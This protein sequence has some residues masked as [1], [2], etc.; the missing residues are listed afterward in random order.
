MPLGAARGGH[1]W[2]HVD[3]GGP[4]HGC[5]SLPKSDMIMLLRTL[6]PA[7][8]PVAVLGDAATLAR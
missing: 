6:D 4:T 5:V 7:A 2:F 1:I 8:H 3:H